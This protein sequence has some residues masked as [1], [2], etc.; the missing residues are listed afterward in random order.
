M[1]LWIRTHINTQPSILTPTIYTPI[2]KKPP[3]YNLSQLHIHTLVQHSSK[4]TIRGLFFKFWLLSFYLPA[5]SHHHQKWLKSFK[6]FSLSIYS[7]LCFLLMCVAVSCSG[8]NVP[9]N[10]TIFNHLSTSHMHHLHM[11]TLPSLKVSLQIKYLHPFNYENILCLC[12][13]IHLLYI[14]SLSHIHI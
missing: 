11:I 2:Q 8:I 3:I 7:Y 5:R 14:H 6:I 10:I 4:N 12:P 9:F 1:L 13:S